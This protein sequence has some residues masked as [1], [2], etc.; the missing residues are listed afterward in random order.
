MAWRREAVKKKYNL[1]QW[2]TVCKLKENGGAK[3]VL[4]LEQ[5]NRSLL[6]KWLFRFKDPS[7]N[8]RWK[9]IIL[10]KYSRTHNRMLYS[11][12]WRSILEDESL[13]DI[14][15]SKEVGAGKSVYF[16]TDTWIGNLPLKVRF[17]NLYDI[18]YD[19]TLTVADAFEKYN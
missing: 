1:V 3:R 9:E 11:P 14:S 6:A 17:P 15:I 10:S 13:V 7:Y 5:M 16:W 19:K 12:F 4:D 2:K 18:V 8:S